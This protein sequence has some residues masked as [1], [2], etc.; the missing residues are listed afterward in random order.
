MKRIWVPIMLGVMTSVAAFST[1][2]LASYSTSGA[3]LGLIVT[4]MLGIETFLIGT[5]IYEL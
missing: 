1:I 5:S 4:V 2:K 3:T